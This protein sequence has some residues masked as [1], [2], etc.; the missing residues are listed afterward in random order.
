MANCANDEKAITEFYAFQQLLWKLEWTISFS[1]KAA[2]VYCLEKL[3]I[4]F[5]R[6]TISFKSLLK[7]C[8]MLK[9][10]EYNFFNR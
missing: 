6:K 9:G 8:E 3:F 7:Q 1:R 10:L 5:F 4:Q 2:A